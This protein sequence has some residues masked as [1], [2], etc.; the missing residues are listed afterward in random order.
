VTQTTWATTA[1]VL[2]LTGKAVTDAQLEQANAVIELR[3]SRIY[4]IAL[5][6][7]GSRDVEW[8]RRA[9][10]YQV[11]WQLSQPDLYGRLDVSQVGQEGRAIALKDHAL[12]LAPLARQAL[13]RVS[14]LKSRSL[15][16]RSA[17][18]DG[19]GP[20]SPDPASSTNDAYGVWES[21]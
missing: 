12:V 1:D 10:A 7:T 13:L 3:T 14:W 4:T 2:S 20:V 15:H 18:E 9:C 11:A 5:T 8:L 17:F 16:V 6:T 21:F 19:L